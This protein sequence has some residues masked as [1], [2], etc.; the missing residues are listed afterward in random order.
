MLKVVEQDRDARV[1]PAKESASMAMTEIPEPDMFLHAL[2]RKKYDQWCGKLLA[3]GLLTLHSWSTAEAFA[4]SC[5]LLNEAAKSGKST[6]G[7][8]EQNGKTLRMLEGILN[9]AG[10]SPAAVKEKS[11]YGVFGFAQATRHARH[12]QD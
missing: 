9:E 4:F 2:G 12:S 6:R 8:L 10:V 3:A 1:M 11:N 5:D 7:A